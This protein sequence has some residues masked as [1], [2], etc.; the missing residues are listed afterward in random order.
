MNIFHLHEDPDAAAR[1]HCDKHVGKMLTEAVQMMSTGLV[2]KGEAAPWKPTFHNHPMCV[3][4]RTS[5]DNFGWTHALA[6]ALAAEY[7]HRFDKRHAA[8]QHPDALAGHDW[9][10]VFGHAG[11]TQ[12]PLCMPDVYKTQGD[13]IR[14]YRDYYRGEKARFARYTRRPVPDFMLGANLPMSPEEIAASRAFAD[15]G[16][17]LTPRTRPVKASLRNA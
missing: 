6:R 12:A 11:L 14:S 15:E 7:E 16:G 1:L 5:A 17:T 4:V 8:G 9:R 3:W 2:L 13:V 10:A